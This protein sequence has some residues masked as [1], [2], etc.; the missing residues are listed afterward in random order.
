MICASS[1]T[2]HPTKQR[3]SVPRVH[4]LTVPI[5]SDLPDLYNAAD[6]AA[7]ACMTAK[8][9]VEKCLLS[10]LEEARQ[11]VQQKVRMQMGGEDDEGRRGEWGGQPDFL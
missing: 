8:L 6:G 3:I 9:A 2:T 11:A 10:R 4:S 5:V 7:L 1:Y